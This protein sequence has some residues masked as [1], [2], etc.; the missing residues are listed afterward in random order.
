MAAP[1]TQPKNFQAGV[2][3][4]SD[5][6][7]SAVT[8]T[9]LMGQGDL[10][11]G[12][13]SQYLNKPVAYTARTVFLG[14]GNGAPSF[15]QISGSFLVGNVAGNTNSA[16]GSFTEF[17]TGKGAYSA[18]ISTIGASRIMTVD[19]RQTIEGTNWG[20]TADETIDFE[21]CQVMVEFQEREEGNLITWTATCYGN[22]IVTSNTNVITYAQAA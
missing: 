20:D 19:I 22:I 10:K 6:T 13:L 11:F 9:W 1:S 15:P 16:P 5:G 7:G 14:L 12:P 2:T 3:R 17:I 8:L 18:N 4:L 21:D